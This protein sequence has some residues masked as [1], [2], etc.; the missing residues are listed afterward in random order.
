MFVAADAL[1]LKM[2][3]N[4]RFVGVHAGWRSSAIWWP[5]ASPE[6]AWWPVITIPAWSPRSAPRC[7]G[8]LAALQDSIHRQPDAGHPEIVMSLGSNL[9]DS[10]STTRFIIGCGPI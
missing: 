9:R 5:G 10:V 4:G 1:A 6:P 8:G 3:E 2:R 7:R